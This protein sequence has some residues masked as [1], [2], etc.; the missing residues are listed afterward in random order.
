MADSRGRRCIEVVAGGAVVAAADLES[1][2]DPTVIRA[3]LRAGAGHAP[4]GARARLVDALL[5]RRRTRRRRRLEATLP[6]GD[7]EALE[8]LRER[9]P[10]LRARPAGSTCLVDARLPDT[11]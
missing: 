11:D 2:D 6:L 10:D 8:R 5:D 3:S 7:V 1:V 9:C 4:V